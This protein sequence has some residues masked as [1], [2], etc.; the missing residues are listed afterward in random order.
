MHKQ[1]YVLENETH[2]ILWDSEVQMD[3]TLSPWRSD[4]VLINEQKKKK[5]KKK[6]LLSSGFYCSCRPYVV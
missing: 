1:E 3:H 6:N 4:S 5:K 2:K